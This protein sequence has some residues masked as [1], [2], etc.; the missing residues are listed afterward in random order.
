MPMIDPLLNPENGNRR[1]GL[2]NQQQR[3]QAGEWPMLAPRGAG[4]DGYYPVF[5]DKAPEQ[6]IPEPPSGPPMTAQPVQPA[7]APVAQGFQY[8]DRS[9]GG[10]SPVGGFSASAA[11]QKV[12]QDQLMRSQLESLLDWDSPYMDRA[13]QLGIERASARGLGNSS[14]AAGNAMGAAIDRALPIAQFDASR[15][16]DV[17]NRNQAAT[18]TMRNANANRGL[19]AAT[20]NASHQLA[21][22]QFA[23]GQQMDVWNANR[24]DRALDS[25]NYNSAFNTYWNSINAIYSNPNISAEQQTAAVQNVREMFPGFANDAWG[26]I[27][28]ELLSAGAVPA[29][30]QM[31][32]MPPIFS[33]VG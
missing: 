4:G 28:P 7:P 22:D 23:H 6:G 5:P 2:W 16:G 31:P 14:I 9:Q 20:F 25:Q 12:E 29:A 19:Q 3:A 30:Q 1:D 26:A 33:P 32:P 17:A 18:N 21:R 11:L 8:Q 27:P 24:A 13:R 10:F 15:Y